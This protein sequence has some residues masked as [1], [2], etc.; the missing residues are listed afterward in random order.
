MLDAFDQGLKQKSDEMLDA[1]DLLVYENYA[2]SFCPM[3]INGE[4]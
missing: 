1:F 3:W 4:I 2:M